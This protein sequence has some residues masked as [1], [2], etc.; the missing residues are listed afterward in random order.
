MAIGLPPSQ[1][2]MLAQP[3]A[4]LSITNV[5]APPKPQ[6]PAISI[7]DNKREYL[8]QKERNDLEALENELKREK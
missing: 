2:A 4:Q 5:A 3:S 6:P 7:H 1:P 8:K